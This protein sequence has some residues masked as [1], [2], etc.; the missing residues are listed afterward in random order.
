MQMLPSRAAG[1]ISAVGSSSL[2]IE[3]R[4]GESKTFVVD[5]NTIIRSRSGSIS[6]FDDLEVGMM[7]VVRGST[8]DDGR[9]LARWLGVGQPPTAPAGEQGEVNL[10]AIRVE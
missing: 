2:T 6:S 3:N 4:A 1:K 8:L 7:A 10:P 5:G 9:Q